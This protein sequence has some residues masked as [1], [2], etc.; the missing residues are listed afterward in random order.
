MLTKT[1]NVEKILDLPH[2]G[3]TIIAWSMNAE[4]VSRKFEIGAPAFQRRLE[5]AHK[6]QEAGYPVRI[7]LDPV[8]PFDGWQEAYAETAKTIFSRIS[9][10][11][12]TIGTLRFEEG[13]YNMRNTIFTTGPV[14]PGMMEQMAPMFKPRAFPGSKRPRHGKYSFLEIQ[15]VEIFQFI[16]NEIRKFSDC[17]IALCKESASVRRKLDLPLSRCSCVCQLDYADMSGR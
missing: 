12:M 1:D 2:N 10:Q 9:P 7:R 14:L 17:R 6:V 5:A 16:I 4:H 15:R 11:R 8:V 3:H 13:F